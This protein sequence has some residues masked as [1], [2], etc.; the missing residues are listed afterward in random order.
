[1]LNRPIFIGF[2]IL[3]LSKHLM[4]ETYYE[5]MQTM[6]NEVKLLYTYCDS[7]VLHIKDSNIYKIMGENEDLFDFSDYPKEHVLYSEK[8]KE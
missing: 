2:C 6:F 8:N 7:F 3:G 1:V 4:Y 5:K